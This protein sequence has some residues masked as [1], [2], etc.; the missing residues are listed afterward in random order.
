MSHSKW[1]SLCHLRSR[2]STG[3]GKLYFL[4]TLGK[5]W[6]YFWFSQL[7]TQVLVASAGW[8]PGMMLSAL[9]CSG[10][11]TP[12]IQPAPDVNT[13]E[14]SCCLSMRDSIYLPIHPS[15][16]LSIIYHLPTYLP[17]YL[18]IHPSFHQPIHACIC[19]S[20]YP[21]IHPSIPHLW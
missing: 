10:R 14:V 18:P 15:Q 3:M 9:S 8:T 11:P 21:S 13:A 20:L 1:A 4:G 19:P 5:V 17:M 2:S 6:R 7:R 16:Y 12:E